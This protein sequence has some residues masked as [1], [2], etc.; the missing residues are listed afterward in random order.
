MI[1]KAIKWNTAQDTDSSVARHNG[2]THFMVLLNLKGDKMKK[3]MQKLDI[4][5]FELCISGLMALCVFTI[6]FE[7]VVGV[8]R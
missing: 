4:D 6:V 5:N 7:F 3:T 8:F 1:N 2:A